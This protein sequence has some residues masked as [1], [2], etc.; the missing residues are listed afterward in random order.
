MAFGMLFEIATLNFWR[1]C[2]HILQRRAILET[3]ISHFLFAGLVGIFEHLVL[4]MSVSC[5]YFLFCKSFGQCEMDV[6]TGPV[7]IEFFCMYNVMY[8]PSSP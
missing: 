7:F 4:Y 5:V 2:M 1:M 8:P 6:L 3:S